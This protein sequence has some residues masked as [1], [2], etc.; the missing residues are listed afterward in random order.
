[1]RFFSRALIASL[2]VLVSLPALALQPFTAHYRATYM[3]HSANAVMV[4]EAADNGQWRYSLKLKN[5]LVEF[6]YSTLFDEQGSQ[7]RPL[8]SVVASTIPFRRR[9]VEG[10]YDWNTLQAT[11]SGDAKSERRGPVT[12]QA[13]DVDGALINLAIVRDIASGKAL[14]YRLVEGGRARERHYQIIA[15][16][17]L[18]VN[19]Q[20]LQTT[21]VQR[22]DGDKEELAWIAPNLPFPV[23]LLQ[24]EK[25]QDVQDLVLV[26]SQAGS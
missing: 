24:R 26:S 8:N 4:L 20:A 25:G 16:E 9:R 11:W 7:F 23:R 18:T 17:T 15:Q 1:M 22:L 14:S 10:H 5:V 13:G 3:G 19:G 6:N 21:K 2:L 12:L